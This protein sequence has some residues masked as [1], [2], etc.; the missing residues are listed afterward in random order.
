MWGLDRREDPKDACHHR[1]GQ[2]LLAEFDYSLQFH[3]RLPVVNTAVSP[4]RS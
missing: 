1:S 4:L 2:L 3:P